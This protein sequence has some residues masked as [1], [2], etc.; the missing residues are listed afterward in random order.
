[1]RCRVHGTELKKQIPTACVAMELSENEVSD[2]AKLMGHADKV[3]KEIYRQPII[4]RE[5]VQ[6]SKKI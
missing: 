1:M 5:I 4:S 3:H 6:I 2:V